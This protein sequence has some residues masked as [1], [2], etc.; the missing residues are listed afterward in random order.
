MKSGVNKVRG[1]VV[2]PNF[3]FGSDMMRKADF[4]VV[5]KFFSVYFGQISQKNCKICKC[6]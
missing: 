5:F 3:R 1:G 6:D 4:D 2:W